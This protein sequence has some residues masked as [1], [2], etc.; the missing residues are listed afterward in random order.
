MPCAFGVRRVLG[1]AKQPQSNHKYV[2][3]G[4]RGVLCYLPKLTP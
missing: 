3:P 4:G 1:N 2:P